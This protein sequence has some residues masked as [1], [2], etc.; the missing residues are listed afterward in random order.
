[1]RLGPVDLTF[2]EGEVREVT[3][4]GDEVVQ[5][6]FPTVRDASWSTCTPV[7]V[8]DATDTDGAS[9]KYVADLGYEIDGSPVGVA[10]LCTVVAHGTPT[11]TY[12]LRVRFGGLA[13]Y[14][15]VGLTV[16]H[17]LRQSGAT[18]RY[19]GGRS[20]VAAPAGVGRLP[21]LV[22]PQP[23]VDGV[24]GP[25]VGPFRHLEIVERTRTVGLTFDGDD[26]EMED[27]RNWSDASFKTYCTPLALGG[28]HDALPGQELRHEVT[29]TAA[30]SGPPDDGEVEH[31]PPPATTVRRHLRV[32]VIVDA[33]SVPSGADSLL[34]LAV[35]LGF[36]TLVV[37]ARDPSAAAVP[38][39]VRAARKRR[40]DVVVR[41]LGT[42][43]PPPAATDDGVL[44]HGLP[45]GRV[46]EL[47]ELQLTDLTARSDIWWQISPF[48][49]ANDAWSLSRA[50]ESLPAMVATASRL[51]PGA[52]LWLGPLKHD[53]VEAT[54]RFPP[55]PGAARS[56]APP[57]G[58]VEAWFARILSL[59]RGTALAGI[60]PL[61]L[62]ELHDL[63][64]RA[65]MAAA[66]IS[67]RA[68]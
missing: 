40:L 12:R 31:G 58:A 21:Y 30:S 29:V 13:H 52:R 57:P 33:G 34:D 36:D 51:A 47:V 38:A 14:N 64:R 27:Q 54:R 44:W 5:R 10:V 28:P 32:G 1:M 9:A 43:G 23:V 39:L 41:V 20:R 56:P 65:E 15:R 17:P 18:L 55:A 60:A 37:D 11:L 48:V 61:R 67:G 66:I 46:L 2:T 22:A 8:R 24:A 35:R 62:A 59:A 63:D 42:A 49:H 26:F 16:L 6:L 7:V 45:E 68:R 53:A 25:F 19:S 4:E 3:V 50:P